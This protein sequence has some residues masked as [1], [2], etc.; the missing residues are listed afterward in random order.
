MHVHID[1]SK[2]VPNICAKHTHR[3]S[4]SKNNNTSYYDK[5]YFIKNKGTT[6]CFHISCTV[7]HITS[8]CKWFMW[9]TH[10]PAVST[11]FTNPKGYNSNSIQV[12]IKIKFT[13]QKDDFNLLD[14]VSSIISTIFQ[15]SVPFILFFHFQFSVELQAMLLPSPLHQLQSILVGTKLQIILLSLLMK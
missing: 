3:H 9:P 14:T 6:I 1:L 11:K 5:L 13:P 7:S 15:L 2:I 8:Q 4:C 10:I 12:Q